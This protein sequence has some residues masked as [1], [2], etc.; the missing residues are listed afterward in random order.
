MSDADEG[1]DM[2]EGEPRA[3]I[4]ELKNRLKDQ[5][6]QIDEM[7]QKRREKEEAKMEAIRQ[8]G[9]MN[10]AIIADMT[11]DTLMGDDK[12]P[13]HKESMTN[14][15]E[16]L[17]A[18]AVSEKK[19]FRDVV[20]FVMCQL[21]F[22]SKHIL[23]LKGEA[24]AQEE[25]ADP[26][27]T[28]TEKQPKKKAHAKPIKKEATASSASKKRQAPEAEEMPDFIYPPGVK[29][30]PPATPEEKK[31]FAASG[32]VMRTPL[33]RREH[34]FFRPQGRPLQ[35]VQYSKK[36]K[37]STT[38]IHDMWESIDDVRDRTDESD[39]RQAYEAKYKEYQE[40]MKDKDRRMV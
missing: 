11:N 6:A 19:K 26:P 36:A 8:E 25:S 12:S 20:T 38:R 30:L 13:E 40:S 32:G 24:S 2:V 21:E 9:R 16:V 3:E 1:D 22:A 7:T 5:Q 37:Q 14:A 15:L 27:P 29:K 10:H 18:M 17:E 35:T 31:R 23:S 33:E 34:E 28:K 39:S 4:E